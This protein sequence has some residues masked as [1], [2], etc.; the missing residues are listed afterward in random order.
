MSEIPSNAFNSGG[1]IDPDYGEFPVDV[2]ATYRQ[3]ALV[4]KELD[5]VWAVEAGWMS[6]E[7]VEATALWGNTDFSLAE[8][9]DARRTIIK[10]LAEL[11]LTST[12]LVSNS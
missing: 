12:E 6:K 11:S 9:L 7:T 3:T 8:T 2:D 4:Q 5:A 10:N 1:N